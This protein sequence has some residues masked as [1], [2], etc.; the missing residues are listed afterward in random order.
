MSILFLL[1]LYFYL[2]SLSA[3]HE[4]FGSP[5]SPREVQNVPESR[6]LASAG[7]NVPETNNRPGTMDQRVPGFSTSMMDWSTSSQTARPKSADVNKSRNDV[8]QSSRMSGTND[9]DIPSSR[10][11]H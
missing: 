11:F 6:S 7:K 5:P 8:S 9:L 1:R 3:L 10:S 4:S 2:F